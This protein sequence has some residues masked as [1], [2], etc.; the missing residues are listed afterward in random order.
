[1]Q[2]HW[3]GAPAISTTGSKCLFDAHDRMYQA[4]VVRSPANMRRLATDQATTQFSSTSLKLT[5]LGVKGRIRKHSFNVSILSLI[6]TCL[7]LN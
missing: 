7:Y 1:M 6:R 4:A 3:N 2:S 5:K